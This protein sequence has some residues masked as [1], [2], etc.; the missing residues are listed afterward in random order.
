MPKCRKVL[1]KAVN[2]TS[3]NR[4]FEQFS[5]VLLPMNKEKT[6]LIFS[7]KN[8]RRRWKTHKTLILV[9]LIL[10]LIV[11]PFLYILIISFKLLHN[12]LHRIKSYQ[13][14]QAYY[15]SAGVI[16][17]RRCINYARGRALQ[18][19]FKIFFGKISQ[20]RKLS[21]SAEITLLHIFIHWDE[22]YY[23]RM[24]LRILLHASLS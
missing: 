24:L 5:I 12:F 6:F 1:E 21:H 9:I 8:S 23:Y 15:L 3:T 11:C 7:K 2:V 20:C 17:I 10:L 14:P 19:I 4:G 13:Y 22:L 16:I 18:N